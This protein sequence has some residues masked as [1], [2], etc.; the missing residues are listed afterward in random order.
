MLLNFSLYPSGAGN[1]PFCDLIAIKKDA[2]N[3]EKMQFLTGNARLS[4]LL[5]GV[6][7]GHQ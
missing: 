6:V 4:C 7:Y 5:S 1:Q 2:I 3:M